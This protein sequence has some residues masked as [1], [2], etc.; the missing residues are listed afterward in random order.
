MTKEQMEEMEKHHNPIVA[1]WFGIIRIEL[2]INETR[3]MFHQTKS[4]WTLLQLI[5]RQLE[6]MN[7]NK[8][9][10]VGYPSVE[11]EYSIA[12]EEQQMEFK[13]ILILTAKQEEAIM[14]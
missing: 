1:K 14:K 13:E 4:K 2:W 5:N 7:I 10:P 6:V 12:T 9:T 8:D 11:Y 3:Y